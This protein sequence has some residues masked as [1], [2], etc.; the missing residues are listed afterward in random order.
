MGFREFVGGLLGFSQKSLTIRNIEE[1]FYPVQNAP[2]LGA[3]A[4]GL[5]SNVIMAPVMWVMRTFTEA[6][7]VVQ[8]RGDRGIWNNIADHDLEILI[9]QPNPFYDGDAL[10][11]GTV[12]SYVMA[13]N[14]YWRKVRNA[15]G[16]VVGLW[17]LPHWLVTPV[18][19]SD[20]S[21]FVDHYQYTS[22]V[23]QPDRIAPRDIVH[24]R[25]GIDPENTMLGLSPMRPVW[26]E[27][28]T[29]DS[30]SQFSQV[31]LQNMGVP[32]LVISPKDAN[33]KP[34]PEA[35]KEMKDFWETA[36]S[37]DRRGKPVI[38]RIPTEVTQFGFDPNKLMLANLRDISE[39]R[40][41]AALGI[42][43]AVVGFGSGLQSTKVGA[44]MRE[45]RRLAWVQCLTPMQKSIAKQVTAQLLPDF[46]AP[47]HLRRFRAR[48]DTSDV[49]SFPEDDVLRT[50]RILSMV[51]G[52]VLRVDRAQEMLGIEVDKARNIYLGPAELTT[53]TAPPSSNDVTTQEDVTDTAVDDAV[54][55]S[56]KSADLLP[57]AIVARLATHTNGTHE[58]PHD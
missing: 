55:T 28:G 31:I 53:P 41:C 47:S 4:N 26:R 23:G 49:S 21:A 54:D 17:Y 27:I 36:F 50:N 43:A 44:T 46:Q 3:N 9:D 34:S 16:G 45:L 30:A 33:V 10:M 22:G 8:K 24:L 2:T 20:G 42:P 29:D 57:A 51:A 40:V 18:R 14:A 38:T 1:N 7:L 13:G 56:T 11:K 58:A 37:G 12:V 48:F 5:R 25:F 35:V 32:G 15:F 52:G 19:A 39:E 6:E